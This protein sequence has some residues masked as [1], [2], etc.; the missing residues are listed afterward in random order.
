MRTVVRCKGNDTAES[1]ADAAAERNIKLSE[2]K[3]DEVDANALSKSMLTLRK[4]LR[5]S[6]MLCHIGWSTISA[7]GLLHKEDSHR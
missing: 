2:C 6:C 1:N 4:G 5:L 7:D 3:T